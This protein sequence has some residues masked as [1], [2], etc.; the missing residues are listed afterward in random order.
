MRIE[1]ILETF[2]VELKVT[3][4][5][6]HPDTPAEGMTLEQLFAGRSF[7][8]EATQDR[9]IE[10][11]AAEGLPFG[12]RTHTYNSRRAQ[13]LAKWAD[14]QPGGGAIHDALF[15]A[16]FVDG[17]N[18]AEVD[19]LARIA[20]SVGLSEASAREVVTSG[21][22]APSVDGDWRR[23]AEVGITGVPTFVFNGHGVVGAQPYEVLEQLVSQHGGERRQPA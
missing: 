8:I 4:F 20:A 18:L 2:D 13:E 17:T 10:A 3:Q 9:L 11:A 1:Q 14:P 21:S 22:F 6:L 5:P 19:E 15:N 23:S 12:R 16:Y 7:D